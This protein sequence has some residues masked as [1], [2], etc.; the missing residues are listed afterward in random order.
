M[1]DSKRFDL[2]ALVRPRQVWVRQVQL[3][4]TR[5]AVLCYVVLSLVGVG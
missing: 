2:F 3:R 5:W 4:Q 1:S